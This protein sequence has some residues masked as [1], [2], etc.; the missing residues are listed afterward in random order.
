MSKRSALHAVAFA[1]TFVVGAVIGGAAVSFRT[2]PPMAVMVARANLVMVGKDAYVMYRYAAYPVARSA[3]L[4]YS[5][6]SQ[7]S[8]ST[9]PAESE[10]TSFDVGLT[11]GRLALAAERAGNQ[12]DAD[13]FMNL[14]KEAFGRTRHS[15]DEAQ[16]RAAVERLDRA[17]DEGLA[18]RPGQ[19]Q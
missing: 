7:N 14:A 18:G 5:D 11:Y 9:A 16:I 12:S 15:Y 19:G 4:K 10:G 3:L 6:Q 17:W 13:T 8:V 1:A 2:I